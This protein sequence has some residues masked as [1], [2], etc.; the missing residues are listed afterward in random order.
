MDIKVNKK[1]FSKIG[2]RLFWGT[3]I[4]VV[5]QLIGSIVVGAINPKLLENYDISL[6]STMIPLYLIGL[7]IMILL[8]KKVDYQKIEQKSMSGKELLSA[9]LMSYAIVILGNFL[10]LGITALISLVKGEGVI[11]PFVEIASNGNL[12]ITAVYTVICA[13]IY[14]EIIFRKLL[15]DR[16]IKYGEK[17]AVIFS[18]VV[19]ALFHGNLNQF[20]YA[21]LIGMFFA[22]IYVK[23]GQVKYCI[24]LH[25]VVNFLGSVFGSIIMTYFDAEKT[26]GM[27]V[28]SLYSVLFYAMIISGIV[29]LIKSL[30]KFKLEAG[31]LEKAQG[32]KTMFINAGMI[33]YSVFWIAN[34]VILLLA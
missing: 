15:V 12:W 1:H 27:I 3:I 30:K 26:F 19:F 9:A 29:I 33:V 24:I 21:L 28:H 18:G 2:F 20:V 11:N 16:T 4:I 14:E 23:T 17:A 25:M 8:L 10:G 7:P 22:F 32:F 34:M 6:A 13:P 5:L 31:Q